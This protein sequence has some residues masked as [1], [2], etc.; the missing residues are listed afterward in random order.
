MFKQEFAVHIENLLKS[1]IDNE[2]FNMDAGMIASNPFAYVGILLG[3]CA[4]SNDSILNE[5]S[6]FIYDLFKEYSDEYFNSSINKFERAND[7]LN[8]L[9]SFLEK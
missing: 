6:G 1:H 2:K 7:F 5:C 8:K 9:R 3:Y 4:S